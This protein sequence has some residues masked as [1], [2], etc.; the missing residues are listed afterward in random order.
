MQVEQDLAFGLHFSFL[1]HISF[2]QFLYFLLSF[3]RDCTRK[4]DTDMDM[5][6]LRTTNTNGYDYVQQGSAASFAFPQIPI[7]ALRSS[8]LAC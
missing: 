4:M 6:G 7:I 2:I 5:H 3:L 8:K 1:L